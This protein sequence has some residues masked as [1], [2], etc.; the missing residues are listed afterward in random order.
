VSKLISKDI[1]GSDRNVFVVI[2]KHLPGGTEENNEELK[3]LFLIDSLFVYLTTLGKEMVTASNRRK[4][5]NDA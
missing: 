5:G 3:M 4:I 2:Y 1:Q